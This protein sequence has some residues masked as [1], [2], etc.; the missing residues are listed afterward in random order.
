VTA[1]DDAV[2][3]LR[4]WVGEPVV[5]RLDPE[6]T[7]MHG[8]LTERVGA[9]ADTALFALD[10]GGLTGVAVALFRDG[11]GAIV[12]DGDQLVVEQGRVT[13]TVARAG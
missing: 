6:G 3:M 13:V 1:F 8:R 7:V 5:V 2:A 11:V 4:S 9:G 10:G 12:R